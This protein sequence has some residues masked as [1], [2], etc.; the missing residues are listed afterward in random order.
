MVWLLVINAPMET[1]SV[2]RRT[3]MLPEANMLPLKVRMAE[4]R[5]QNKS[6]TDVYLIAFKRRNIL[7][8]L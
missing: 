4:V 8:N 2:N 1:D 6:A 5:G 3:G 7:R